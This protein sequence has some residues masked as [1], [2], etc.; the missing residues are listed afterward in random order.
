MIKIINSEEMYNNFI[1]PQDSLYKNL[2]LLVLSLMAETF[3]KNCF[4]N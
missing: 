1:Y 3:N 4:K 2:H